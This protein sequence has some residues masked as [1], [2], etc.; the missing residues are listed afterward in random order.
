MSDYRNAYKY[1]I[2]GLLLCEKHNLD[3]EKIHIYNNLG[4]IY[5]HL[6]KFD[7]AKSYYHKV[8][9]FYEDT[10]SSEN[11]LFYNNLGYIEVLD[12]NI[13]SAYYYL[14]KAMQVLF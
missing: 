9:S 14:S 4:V 13:D 7:I 3:S 1:L 11:D 5:F 6:N 2:D 8:L 10:V 12:N